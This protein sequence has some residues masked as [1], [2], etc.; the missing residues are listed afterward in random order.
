MRGF[1]CSGP[2]SSSRYYWAQRH[3][4][5]A[6][7][8]GRSSSLLSGF[9]SLPAHIHRCSLH[10]QRRQERVAFSSEWVCWDDQKHQWADSWFCDGVNPPYCKTGV[11]NKHDVWYV[12]TAPT[13]HCTNPCEPIQAALAQWTALW[14]LFLVVSAV[15]WALRWK[16]GLPLLSAQ[17]SREGGSG[18]SGHPLVPRPRAG[19]SP[20]SAG[21]SA[22]ASASSRSSLQL[23][24]L[25]GLSL[26]ALSAEELAV[27]QDARTQ[28]YRRLAHRM[29]IVRA[30]LYL[31]FVLLYG[32]GVLHRNVEYAIRWIALPGLIALQVDAIQW[33]VWLVDSPCS[34]FT[35]LL[36]AQAAIIS[37][38]SA[39]LLLSLLLHLQ[40][41]N[42][43][44]N[45]Q[46]A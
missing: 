29:M 34:A 39:A 27:L 17:F 28:L 8:S 37:S 3:E 9:D 40:Q 7:S 30:A 5:L 1:C 31:R 2:Q 6:G 4:R 26:P 11:Y 38:T 33:I 15:T 10:D 12:V 23:L 32:L 36:F 13:S 44:A 25:F 20:V 43:L 42:A 16:A 18:G 19:S 35:T 21:L 45:L 22:S 41:P 24:P 46:S 14:L